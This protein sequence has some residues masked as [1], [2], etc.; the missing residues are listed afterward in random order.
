MTSICDLGC[1]SYVQLDPEAEFNK[2]QGLR[3]PQCNTKHWLQQKYKEAIVDANLEQKDTVVAAHEADE[4][5]EGV[6][7]HKRPRLVLLLLDQKGP[8]VVDCH[9]KQGYE[10]S[11]GDVHCRHKNVLIFAR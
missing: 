4:N 3:H 11:S 7:D 1:H 2:Y 5:N 9:Q 10:E 8:N 6:E